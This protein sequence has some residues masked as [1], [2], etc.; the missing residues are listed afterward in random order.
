MSKS[1]LFIA[2]L[3]LMLGGII[4]LDPTKEIQLYPNTENSDSIYI[5]S[6]KLQKNIPSG[7][8]ILVNLDWYSSAL[9]PYRC[10]M[11]NTTITLECTNFAAPSFTLTITAAQLLEHNSLLSTTKTVAVLLK[12][13]LVKNTEYHLQL[14][15]LNIVP[16]IRKISPSA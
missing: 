16:N 15:L 4:S 1:L 3:T 12:S 2:I 11:V 8:Y 9:M 10:T 13:N 14:H 5:F 7:S 6:F